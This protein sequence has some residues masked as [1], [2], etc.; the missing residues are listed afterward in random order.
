MRFLTDANVPQTLT[1]RLRTVGHDVEEVL[2]WNPSADDTSVL[3]RAN[4]QN[5]TLITADLWFGNTAI[6]PVGSY[7]VMIIIRP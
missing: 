2:E 7:P 1:T 6:H 5:R 4:E 3:A